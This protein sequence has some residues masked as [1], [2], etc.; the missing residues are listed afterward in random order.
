MSQQTVTLSPS[1]S[2]LVAFEAIPYEAKTYSVKVDGLTGSFKAISP[3]VIYGIITNTKTGLPVA[4]ALIRA[5]KGLWGSPD[6]F[7]SDYSTSTGDYRIENV[8]GANHIEVSAS[9]YETAHRYFS[10][11]VEEGE[12]LRINVAL[13]PV[14]AP[15]QGVYTCNVYYCYL[16]G[17]EGSTLPS[18]WH[19][20]WYSWCEWLVGYETNLITDY[21]KSQG[22]PVSMPII[23]IE[24][25]K[26]PPEY[27]YENGLLKHATFFRDI[28]SKK[29]SFLTT[30]L[31][32]CL[33]ENNYQMPA[34]FVGYGTVMMRGWTLE[35]EIRA[36]EGEA[37]Y[38]NMVYCELAH[39]FGHAF[40]LGHCAA[41]PCPM[42]RQQ[43]TYTEWINMGKRLW[44]CDTH[45]PIFL[46]NWEN[47]DFI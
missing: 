33:G 44:F 41:K 4:G 46:D 43:I 11:P 24:K 5:S 3:T 9:G 45:R 14:A 27:L 10:S 18:A 28:I 30:D 8:L 37:F 13:K 17:Y 42:A 34:M 21:I 19:S 31:H 47:R 36:M 32:I 26:V 12:Q 29:P 23:S 6:Y 16:E 1:Q 7:A 25:V 15:G 39:E 2:K 35:Q 20:N 40:H 38:S 22:L